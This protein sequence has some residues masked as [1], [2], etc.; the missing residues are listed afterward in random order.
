MRYEH[1]GRFW[2]ITRV[3]SVL[4]IIAGKIG[5]KGRTVVKHHPNEGAAASAHDQLVLEKQRE[6]YRIAADVPVESPA[7]P[8]PLDDERGPAL[9]D[10]IAANPDDATAFAVYGD[11]LHKHGDPR[12]EL[13]ALQQATGPKA[14][15]AVGKHIALHAP[16]LLGSL[17]ALVRD[18][19]DPN[20][21]PFF[22]QHGFIRRAELGSQKEYALDRVVGELLAHPSA[23][24]L[25]ELAVRAFDRR[26]A[27]AII[28]LV[29]ANA[30]ATLRELDLFAR[31]NLDR[32]DPA[33]WPALPRLER[34][35]ITARAFAL[36]R[37]ALPSLV[38]GK[39]IATSMSSAAV[40]AIAVAPWPVLER[41]EIRF[42]GV[43]GTTEADFHDL[44]PLLLR[45]DMPKL[46]HLKLRG[47]AFAGAVA[48]TLAAAPLSRQ[49][50]VLDFSAGDFSPQDLQAL[51]TAASNFP[52]LRELWLPYTYVNPGV[53]KMLAP[54]AKR[55]LPD[56]K[57]PIDS[58][59]YDLAGESMP[60]AEPRY[61]GV[62]E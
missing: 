47:C 61:G 49:L 41:L 29:R 23:K 25:V 57:G 26:E 17:A 50:H 6:G 42:C 10:A 13:V 20:A 8:L 11:W 21:A 5:N 2:T 18:V 35:T 9:E 46:T 48:R 12:G 34:L 59:D 56:S 4:T 32:I 55:V 24:F 51:A 33:L 38:R 30:P 15:A 44:R 58:V 40:E 27:L 31:A 14:A 37:F 54:V 52:N 36:E 22:W 28:Q 39:F 16:Q 60:R 62:R 1:A 43:R 53:E 7:Q 3:G 19:R 45:T